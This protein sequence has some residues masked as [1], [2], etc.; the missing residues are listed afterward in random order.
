MSIEVEH[1]YPDL[2]KV[3]S[4]N[5]LFIKGK[6]SD[7]EYD[8]SRYKK[9]KTRLQKL[10]QGL[11]LTTTSVG[12]PSAVVTLGATSSLIAGLTMPL[13]IPVGFGIAGLVTLVLD[14]GLGAYLYKRISR[15][16]RKI[17]HGE[18][19]KAKL[20]FLYLKAIDDGHITHDE[21][22]QFDAIL[23]E[24]RTRGPKVS[25]FVSI[26]EEVPEILSTLN[27]KEKKL[28]QRGIKKGLMNDLIQS[29]VKKI[30]QSS[31]SASI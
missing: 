16:R 12:L 31:S 22:L 24:Y 14:L 30:Q 20:E 8:I 28:V 29:G 1:L 4:A 18:V 13:A 19:Y 23:Q 5:T 27:S 7:L 11:R 3:E 15:A 10:F 9:A 2:T 21:L 6:K 26:A 17:A 25:P